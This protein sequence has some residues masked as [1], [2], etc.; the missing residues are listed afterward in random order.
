MLT[1]IV[2]SWFAAGLLAAVGTTGAGEVPRYVLKPGQVVDYEERQSFDS[3]QRKSETTWA[4]RVWVVGRND[5]GS[6]RV[7]IRQTL[8]SKSKANSADSDY[9]STN[10]SRFDVFPDGKVPPNPSLGYSIDP[11]HLFPRLPDDDRQTVDGW[12]AVDD[13]DDA[14]IRYK[15]SGAADGDRFN[16]EADQ[17]SFMERIYEGKDHRVFQFDRKKGLVTHAEIARAFGSHM[18]GQG[19]GSLEL[20]AVSEMDPAKLPT[21]RAEM[22]HCFDANLAYQEL[23][24]K[25]VKSGGEAESTLKKARSILADARAKLTLPEPIAALDKLIEDHDRFTKYQ[26]DEAKKFADLI[27]KPAAGWGS[28]ETKSPAVNRV[29]SA[30]SKSNTASEIKDLDGHSHSLA[31]YRGKVL[32]LDFWYR[33]CGWCMRAMPQV[34]RVAAHY[35]DKPVAVFGVNNDQEEKDARF[36]VKE[37]AIAYPV[38]RSMDLAGKYGVQGF[39]TLVIIDQEG[40]VADVHVGYSDHLYEDVTA[41]IDRL[42]AQAK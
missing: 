40:K 5:D 36:V 34:K 41:T 28:F 29:V 32:V 21:F 39:P 35:R 4:S 22:D 8:K 12:Q 19:Q 37:M 2:R 17:V 24:A 18:N 3:A 14:T 6:A 38:L 27:G 10:F 23:T 15:A 42:M 7:V 16:F 31:Q 1:S 9:E 33:G 25:V 20:K 30:L 13:R 26:I 11:A